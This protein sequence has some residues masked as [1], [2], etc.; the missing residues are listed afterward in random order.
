MELLSE[1]EG[2]DAVRFARQTLEERIGG[3]NAPLPPSGAVFADLRGVFVTLTTGGDLRG[4]IGY[5]YPVLPLGEAV[6]EAAIAAATGDPRFPPVTAAEL[7]EITIEVTVLTVPAP[8]NGAPGD[9]AAGVI[10]GRHGL[11]VSGRG[12]GGLLLPQVATEYGWDAA[13]FLDHTCQKA[14]LPP[15]C[16][17]RND[18]DVLTFEGQIFH[19]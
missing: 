6:R 12:T 2:R 8:L 19:E 9:R 18:I 5:P 14:G 7:P 11:I 3:G 17:R 4:C 15:G 10:P 16:W 1:E 13:T